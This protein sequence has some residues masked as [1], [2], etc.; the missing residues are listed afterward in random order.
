MTCKNGKDFKSHDECL[1]SAGNEPGLIRVFSGMRGTESK[2]Y[3]M[4]KISVIY[5]LP[6]KCN[7]CDNY[8]VIRKYYFYIYFFYLIL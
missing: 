6:P 5:Q 1:G 3:K 8:N 4:K 7:V 2:N